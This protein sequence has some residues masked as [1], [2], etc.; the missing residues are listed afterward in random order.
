MGIFDGLNWLTN[1]NAR[2]SIPKS[3]DLKKDI[4]SA[5]KRLNILNS[6]NNE[7]LDSDQRITKKNCGF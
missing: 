7:L 2:L 4:Q 6:Y 5:R 1:H 3:D